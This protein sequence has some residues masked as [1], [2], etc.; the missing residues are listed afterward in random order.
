MASKYYYNDLE[1]RKLRY[2]RGKFIGWQWGGL[3]S[4][5]GAV[6][7]RSRSVIFIPEYLLTSE[8]REAIKALK[9][10]IC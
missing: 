1:S 4:L 3:L 10:G 7:Q 9:E 6:F 2:T 5:R 8:T